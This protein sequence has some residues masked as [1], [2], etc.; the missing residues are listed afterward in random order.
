MGIGAILIVLAVVFLVL[1][2]TGVLGLLLAVALA[3]ACIVAAIIL[4]QGAIRRRF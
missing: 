3:V 4:D 2:F 1:G